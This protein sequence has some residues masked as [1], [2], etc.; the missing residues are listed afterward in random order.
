M[1]KV[2][3]NLIFARINQNNRKQRN[4]N[5]GTNEKKK[6]TGFFNRVRHISD[7]FRYLKNQ[8]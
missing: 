4:M 2:L 6:F 1:Y 5:F 8:N 7:N 3:N